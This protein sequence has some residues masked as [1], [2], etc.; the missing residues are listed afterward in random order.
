MCRTCSLESTPGPAFLRHAVTPSAAVFKASSSKRPSA[1]ACSNF[2]SILFKNS[3][4]SCPTTSAWPPS[5]ADWH[6]RPHVSN[7]MSRIS[8]SMEKSK[9][10]S[11]A[12]A[13]C[14]TNGAYA[15]PNS[16]TKVWTQPT[17][18]CKSSISDVLMIIT[19]TWPFSLV[20]VTLTSVSASRPL[21][22][23]WSA[24]LGANV[25]FSRM[26]GKMCGTNGTKLPFIVTQMRCDASNMY[27]LTGSLLG[28]LGTCV[29]WIIACMITSASA[30]K[31]SGPT[32]AARSEM[33]S[34]VFPSS[35]R[36][37]VLWSKLC[38]KFFR[39]GI[40]GA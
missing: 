26:P 19:L 15:L 3:C 2:G 4:T 39:I 27:S 7:A 38:T 29:A 34:K 21:T 36:S 20:S 33:H 28:K 17:A 22:S 13:V 35:V 30:R 25:N 12:C 31:P 6:S 40:R 14:A 9:T 10:K 16:S 32:E 1:P 37:S 5:R 18:C 11:N 8:S 24:S 23:A